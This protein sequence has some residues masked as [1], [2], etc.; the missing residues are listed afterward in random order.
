MGAKKK[1]FF[2]KKEAGSMYGKNRGYTIL[3]NAQYKQ[4]LKN[5]QEERPRIV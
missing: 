3:N 5:E 4:A 1:D 2:S